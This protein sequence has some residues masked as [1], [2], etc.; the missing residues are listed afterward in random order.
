MGKVSQSQQEANRLA[1]VLDN[2]E[3][4]ADE[5][6]EQEE[7]EESQQD[8]L[9]KNMEISYRKSIRSKDKNKKKK[10]KGQL[11]YEFKNF[12]GYPI[13]FAIHDESLNKD[14]QQIVPVGDQYPINH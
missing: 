4:T 7:F 5:K 11:G 10:G 3:L 13:K 6:A 12:T 2:K 8:L 9:E 14:L 1:K